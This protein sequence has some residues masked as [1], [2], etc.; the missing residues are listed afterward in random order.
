MNFNWRSSRT[1][2]VIFENLRK[3]IAYSI[4][5]A[6]EADPTALVDI[7]NW[8]VEGLIEVTRCRPAVVI[9]KMLSSG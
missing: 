9:S 6:V 3:S 5:V 1:G 2:G 8:A 4:A 7:K